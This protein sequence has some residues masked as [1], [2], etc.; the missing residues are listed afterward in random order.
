MIITMKKII[1]ILFV[2]LSLT[3]CKD[4]FRCFCSGSYC[5]TLNY[6]FTGYDKTQL[7]NK[8]QWLKQKYPEWDV[9]KIR[10]SLYSTMDTC[11]SDHVDHYH[12]FIFNK[13]DTCVISCDINLGSSNSPSDVKFNTIHIT[14]FYFPK[15]CDTLSAC[16]CSN[17]TG[18]Y[19]WQIP[20]Y[21]V[22]NA[23]EPNES[24]EKAQK[25]AEAFFDLIGA[26]ELKE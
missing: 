13:I 18:E 22:V 7:I 6:E 16:E 25:S 10:D 8:I 12:L 14:S 11:Y 23:W 19:F 1:C 26:Y 24:Q 17:G 15:L 2:L 9:L 3:S 20:N 21:N 5:N 4:I